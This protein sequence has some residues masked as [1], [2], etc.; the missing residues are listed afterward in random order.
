[1]RVRE[2]E[3]SVSDAAAILGVHRITIYHWCRQGFLRA[4][5]RDGVYFP[6]L[7]AVLAYAKKQRRI[8]KLKAERAI[9]GQMV[10]LTG[11]QIAV[12][13]KMWQRHHSRKVNS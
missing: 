8:A 7:A 3:V 6:V 11:K 2:D 10:A 13:D 4:R 9:T 5:R 1:M 12:L